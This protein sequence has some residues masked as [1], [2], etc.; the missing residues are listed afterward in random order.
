MGAEMTDTGKTLFAW[1]AGFS[2]LIVA[3]ISTAQSAEAAKRL[4]LVIGNDTYQDIEP[5]ARA[6]A[7]ARAYRQTLEEERG[8]TVFYA[9][10]AGRSKMNGTVSEFLAA[11]SPGDTAMVV[12]SGH[13]VQ[14]DSER[15]DSLYLL[16]IDFPNRDPG[17]GAERHFFDSES[18]NFAR[19][20]DH[21]AARGAKL[22]IFVLDA[23]RN[24]PFNRADGTRAIGQ[25]RGIGRITSARG[26]FVIYAAAPGEV[27]YDSLPGDSSDSV[28]SVFTR[29][30]IK[31]FRAGSYLEDV[32]ND[33]QAEVVK[34]AR[35]AN[36]AQEPYYSDGV[37]GRTC[38]EESCGAIKS[39]EDAKIVAEQEELYWKYCANNKEPLYCR[40]FIDRYPESWRVGL[41]EARLK[42]L[43]DKAKGRDDRTA[44]VGGAEKSGSVGQTD[45]SDTAARKDDGDFTTIA[46]P[47]TGDDDANTKS[48]KS[49]GASWLTGRKDPDP[50]TPG[51][52]VDGPTV[53]NTDDADKVGKDDDSDVKTASVAPDGPTTDGTDTGQPISTDTDDPDTDL[54]S[55]DTDTT[56]TPKTG[57]TDADTNAEDTKVASV[58]PNA[59]EG[60]SLEPVRLTRDQLRD[61]QARLTMLGYRLGGLDGRMGKRTRGAIRSFQKDQ[62][63][64]VDGVVSENLLARLAV[65]VPDEKLEAFWTARAEADRAR[66]ERHKAAHEE[67]ARKRAERRE[68]RR[69]AAAERRKNTRTREATTP[70]RVGPTTAERAAAKRREEA[71]RKRLAEEKRKADA[72]RR[73]AARRKA[74]SDKP[75]IKLKTRDRRQV[76]ERPFYCDVNPR[77][78]KWDENCH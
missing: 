72:R 54:T 55:T 50:V 71:E 3:L 31:H 27:A 9:E 11:I 30:F 20:A 74:E 34:L 75:G 70:T 60:T 64:V 51:D 15:R 62:G 12:Y 67:A 57:T 69:R 14:L 8:F 73:A 45:G 37:A 77:R 39:V 40:A 17:R 29:S 28:N 21:V 76:G 19:L 42:I 10:N 6:V 65:A 41:A 26:E 38:L 48:G 78:A 36:V 2:L 4:A 61:A 16:P 25:S 18:T 32:A 24:N 63:A 58:D 44:S 46:K 53:G 13:G 35:A 43:A 47:T 5:L 68:A 33:V 23:C 1:I 52:S 66:A 59:F 22:R 56:E 49:A 7:D